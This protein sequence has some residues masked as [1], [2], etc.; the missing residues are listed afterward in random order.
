MAQ[1]ARARFSYS[2]YLALERETDR[3]HEY[4]DGE[5]WMMASGT[6]RHSKIKANLLIQVGVALDDGPC[7]PYDSDLKIRVLDTG[8]ATY[9]DL[10]IICGPVERHPDDRNALT[11]PSVLFEV[12]SDSTEAWDRG[13]KFAHYRRISSLQQYVLVNTRDQRVEVYTRQDDG[14]WLFVDHGPGMAAPLVAIS[15]SLSVASVYRNLPEEP[16]T[17]PTTEQSAGPPEG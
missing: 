17:E 15:A 4:L 3:R 7:Q 8:L 10:T 1:P 5:A 2:A 11:N 14:S 12:L 6:P 16:A 13:G 9:P